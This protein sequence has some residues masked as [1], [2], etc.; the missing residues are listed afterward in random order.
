[1]LRLTA[2]NVLALVLANANSY[3]WNTRWTFKQNARHD[4]RQVSLFAVQALLNIGLASVLLWFFARFLLAETALPALAIGNIAKVGSGVIATSSS[5]ML[6]HYVI[7]KPPREPP[8]Q[9]PATGPARNGAG[10][11]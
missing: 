6:S 3:L 9:T 10:S 11:L 2:Y 5:F 1:M 7:F 4:R 8:P